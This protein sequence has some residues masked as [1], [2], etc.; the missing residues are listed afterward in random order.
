MEVLEYK[1]YIVKINKLGHKFIE[2]RQIMCY[3]FKL[4]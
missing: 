3:N 4:F 2:I 1:L